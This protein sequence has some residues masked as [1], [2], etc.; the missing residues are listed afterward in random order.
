ME[1][2]NNNPDWA[3]ETD[4][5]LFQLPNRSFME[6]NLYNQNKDH[7]T[8][9]QPNI[10]ME[11][12]ISIN[13][14]ADQQYSLNAV[15][16]PYSTSDLANLDLWNSHCNTIFIF[17]TMENLVEDVKNVIT[18]LNHIASF[19]DKRNLKNNKE[20]NILFLKGFEQAAW[21]VISA[22]YKSG[23]SKLKTDINN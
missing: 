4:E 3:Q 14:S 5:V 22:I 18:S 17:G 11:G 1:A 2:Q 12:E 8:S 6:E 21:N 10:Y 23:W 7:S 16:L 15:S 20:I 19:I 13:N 9:F